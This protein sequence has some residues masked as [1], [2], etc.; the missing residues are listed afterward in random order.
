[1]DRKLSQK[2]AQACLG[3]FKIA[4]PILLLTPMNLVGCSRQQPDAKPESQQTSPAKSNKADVKLTCP[5]GD[6]VDNDAS[7]SPVGAHSVSLSWNPSTSSDNPKGREIRY[8]LYRTKGGRVQKSTSAR[9]FSPCVNC[10]RVTKEPVMGTA[11]DDTHLENDSRYCYVAISVETVN[12]M[13]SDFSNQIEADIP[14]AG[15]PVFN[16]ISSGTLC[17]P[18]EQHDKSSAKQRHR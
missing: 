13:R 3:A 14:K 1:M 10:Q 7:S 15:V 2:A 11:Y 8:C 9:S 5:P 12:S 4:L 17:N 6:P 16:P 18:K